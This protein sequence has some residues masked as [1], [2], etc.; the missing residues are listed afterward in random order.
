MTTDRSTIREVA[1]HAS[2][3]TATVS[4]VLRNVDRVSP[5]TRRRV[6]AA[7]AEL[8]Y[9][10]NAAGRALA[11]Q[12]HESIGVVVPGLA[13]PY[14]AEIS[15]GCTEAAVEA[16][17]SVNILATHML[18]HS[19]RAVIDLAGRVD[20]LAIMGASIDGSTL[21]EITTLHPNVVIMSQPSVHG[22]PAIHVD[23]YTSTR[24]LVR[25]LVVDHGYRDVVFAG[26]VERSPD[27]TQRWE[28]FQAAL[29]E[30]GGL[31]A[32]APLR[33]G[34]D[35]GA[36]AY[37]YDML[38]LRD[39]L[40]DA[41]FCGNDEIAIGTIHAFTS[42][43][44]SLPDVMAI[45]GWDGIAMS[46]YMSPP[47]TTINQPVRAIGALAVQTLLARIAEQETPIDQ[48]LPTEIVIRQSCGCSIRD[49]VSDSDRTLTTAA[50]L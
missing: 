42:R 47:L 39:R 14:F 2:V 5:D 13:G 25:H 26:N 8:G 21:A 11:T 17:V 15:H 10:P 6:L 30:Y 35:L 16:Q 50:A 48:I 29:A 46:G 38:M 4:R 43:G 24:E 31:P 20:G 18:D 36:G 9:R 49:P 37:V 45:T 3:S 28:A 44:V 33:V 1:D 19:R 22:L 27:G 32:G 23:N 41:L 12:R 40:P 34:F 7:A